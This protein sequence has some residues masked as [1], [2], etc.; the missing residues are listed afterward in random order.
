M[1]HDSLGPDVHSGDPGAERR[2]P[3][4]AS[5]ARPARLVRHN[6]V[7]LGA[8][9]VLTVYTAG[10]ARTRDA[11]H[12]F[13]EADQDA[14]RPPSHPVPAPSDVVATPAV[15]DSAPVAQ[16]AVSPA[17]PSGGEKAVKLEPSSHAAE[18]APVPPAEK[19]SV[20]A[21]AVMTDDVATTALRQDSTVVDSAIAAAETDTVSATTATDTTTKR[22]LLKDGEY[23]G[24][25]T[26]RHGDIQAG[27]Q[28]KDG[29]IAGAW[30]QQCLTR[31]SCSWIAAL[32]GQVVA[33]QSPEVD[34]VSGATQSTNA[35]YYAVVEALSRAK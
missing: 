35:F 18:K 4:A 1:K 32:P 19:A 5:R 9:A 24:W 20:P 2:P 11:A 21:K 22:A 15:N 33:R 26:S 6:L 34:Y 7:A 12:R 30:V 31:Y 28:V 14:R 27:V 10:Y 8:A 25:G 23:Y 29:R 3:E 16:A 17:T 13:E